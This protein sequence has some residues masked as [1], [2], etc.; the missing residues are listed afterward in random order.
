MVL[1]GLIS[2]VAT[3]AIAYFWIPIRKYRSA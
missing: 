2:I 3:L 1:G